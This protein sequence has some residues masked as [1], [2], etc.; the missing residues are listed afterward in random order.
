MTQSSTYWPNVT[1]IRTSASVC[2]EITLDKSPIRACIAHLVR[3]RQNQSNFLWGERLLIL[4]MEFDDKSFCKW[5]V[6]KSIFHTRP[7]WPGLLANFVEL[8]TVVYT[9]MKFDVN[10]PFGHFS[11]YIEKVTVTMD[12][13]EAIFSVLHI[14]LLWLWTNLFA[15]FVELNT[16]VICK[17][18]DDYISFD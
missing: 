15:K 2:Q 3:I 1:Y 11:V 13:W 5:E 16:L 8:K 4:Y 12:E 14:S 7:L 6:I 10:R 9:C 18:Y 17:K